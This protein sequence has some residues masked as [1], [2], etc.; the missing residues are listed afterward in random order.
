M[1]TAILILLLTGSAWA[2]T[3]P[4]PPQADSFLAEECTG[5][6]SDILHFV[7]PGVNIG[8]V[9]QRSPATFSASD[10]S[11]T[12]TL[13]DVMPKTFGFHVGTS[14]SSARFQ[15]IDKTLTIIGQCVGTSGD[16]YTIAFPLLI[17]LQGRALIATG[18]NPLFCR[19]TPTGGVQ[20][21]LLCFGVKGDVGA[22]FQSGQLCEAD[23]V[24]YVCGTVS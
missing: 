18:R 13:G 8:W 10:L 3:C 21:D 22:P 9:D 15:V 19:F 11:G 2:Q 23:R 24:E 12:T 17:S 20:T 4:C 6:T 16:S 5:A 7:L 1:R 14:F